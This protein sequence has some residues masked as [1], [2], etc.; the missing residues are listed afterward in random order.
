M[1]RNLALEIILD[2]LV[3]VGSS[4]VVSSDAGVAA[5]R[6]SCHYTSTT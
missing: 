6:S 4:G 2:P 1:I 3:E 5:R